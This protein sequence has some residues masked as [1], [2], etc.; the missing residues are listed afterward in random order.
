MRK[1]QDAKT[2]VEK[3]MKEVREAAL[4]KNYVTKKIAELAMTLASDGKFEIKEDQVLVLTDLNLSDFFDAVECQDPGLRL[5]VLGK[6]FERY[7]LE[8]SLD[9][10]INLGEFNINDHS[11]SISAGTTGSCVLKAVPQTFKRSLSEIVSLLRKMPEGHAF[12]LKN[13]QSLLIEGISSESMIDYYQYCQENED[14]KLRDL[15][16]DELFEKNC[17]LLSIKGQALKIYGANAK[18]V[19]RAIDINAGGVLFKPV[20]KKDEEETMLVI[21]LLPK[22][23]KSA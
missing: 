5:A 11:W 6:I 10:S 13:R 1:T 18:Q 8:V 3:E 2:H 16:Q 9:G 21:V 23:E 4:Q 20:A 22:G 7:S 17:Q 14:L 19:D 12:V 15:G